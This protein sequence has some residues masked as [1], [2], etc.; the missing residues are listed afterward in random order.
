[1]PFNPN[2][3][4]ILLKGK[5]Y[6]ETKWRLVWLRGEHPDAHIITD[7]HMHEPG[8]ALFRATVSIPNGGSATGWG[9][10]TKEDFGD[11]LEKAE[12]KAIGR[13][14]A[15]LGYG[16]AHAAELDE[17]GS[18]ADS[19]VEPKAKPA[20]SAAPRSAVGSFQAGPVPVADAPAQR[21]SSAAANAPIPPLPAAN[22]A[23]PPTTNLAT[24]G[25]MYEMA[26]GREQPPPQAEPKR[27]P[28]PATEPDPDLVA[29][30]ARLNKA[31]ADR[32]L[33]WTGVVDLAQR[34]WP[35]ITTVEEL[36]TLSSF[37]CDRLAD[38]LKG[39]S[40]I[41]AHGKIVPAAEQPT[42]VAGLA[43]AMR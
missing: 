26:K 34:A 23:Q 15:A 14:L 41:D 30:K 21:Q 7:L 3:H 18:V 9:S 40:I 24:H 11:Y 13:A 2:E 8:Y 43:E 17:G 4:L 32:K 20:T 25:V 12:T 38:V 37:Q 35:H 28:E 19:P 22:L 27:P 36:G 5:Q 33:E 42:I 10:E 31:R 29:A 6:L 39:E 1:V 16:T